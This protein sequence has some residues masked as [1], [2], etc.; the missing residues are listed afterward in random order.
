VFVNDGSTDATLKVLEAATMLVPDSFVID[1]GENVGKANAIREGFLR[2]LEIYPNISWVGFVDADGSFLTEEIAST[3]SLIA[4]VPTDCDAIFTNRSVSFKEKTNEKILRIIAKKLVFNFLVLGWRQHPDDTQS[5]FKFFRITEALI[6]ALA[7][8]FKTGWFFE[9]ELLIRLRSKNSFLN[10]L[11][12]PIK[13]LHQGD[14]H[15]QLKKYPQI[16]FEVLFIK[17]QQVKS[18][19]FR[20]I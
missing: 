7:T 6:I 20:Q 12:V 19:F 13:V 4:E 15:I 11:E 1:L 8:K 17:L 16:L 5:G 14:G 10:I 3:V 9:W 2:I 18:I